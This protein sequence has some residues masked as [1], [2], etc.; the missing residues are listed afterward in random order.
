LNFFRLDPR[1]REPFSDRERRFYARVF[2]HEIDEGVRQLKRAGRKQEA[3]MIGNF[4]SRLHFTSRL[5]FLRKLQ[6]E[7]AILP[8]QRTSHQY[9]ARN[10]QWGSFKTFFSGYPVVAATSCGFGYKESNEDGYLVL[11]DKKI[12]ALTDGMGGHVAGHL[13]SCIAIDF[14]EHAVGQGMEIEEAI[15]YANGAILLRSRSDPRLGGTFPMGCTFAAVQLKHNLLKVA[16]V[17]DTKVLVLRQGRIAFETQ[18]HTQGQQ[19]LREGLVDR[20]TAFELNHI[21]NRCL[22][23]DFLHAQRDVSV[24]QVI[25]QEGDRV[26]I[27]TDGVTDNYFDEQFSLDQLAGAACKGTVAQSA[28]SILQ[29]CEQAMLGHFLPFGRPVKKDNLSLAMLE[30][31]G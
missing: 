16:H 13:A 18:D 22:G 17:G 3:E 9:K 7:G 4:S 25:L 5:E 20:T 6:D 1:T 31:R 10:N 26:L 21:L 27:A 24:S 28:N 14:F 29:Y 15:A 8:A 30:Y 23:L 2:L 12:L 11:S 19:L